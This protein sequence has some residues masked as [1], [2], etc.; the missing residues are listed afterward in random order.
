[1]DLDL[2][3]RRFEAKV[4]ERPADSVSHDISHIKR[5]V[6]NARRIAEAEKAARDKLAMRTATPAVTQ[7]VAWQR[8][9]SAA[10]GRAP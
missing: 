4:S 8:A 9:A 7:Y 10:E 3:E 2:W 6:A 1:M 5:V